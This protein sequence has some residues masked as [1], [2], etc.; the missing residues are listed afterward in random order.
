MAS[1]NP[2]PSAASF[3][4]PALDSPEE[5]EDELQLQQILLDSLEGSSEDTPAKRAELKAEIKSLEQQLAR[6]RGA[7]PNNSFKKTPADMPSHDNRPRSEWDG[8]LWP[9]APSTSRNDLWGDTQ[10]NSSTAS[11]SKKRSFGTHF[12]GD[13]F[14]A[15][16]GPSKSRRTSPGPFRSSFTFDDL[17]PIDLSGED[18][19]ESQRLGFQDLNDKR[20]REEQDAAYARRLDDELN[21]S[22]SASSPM[23]GLLSMASHSGRMH[24]QSPNGSMAADDSGNGDMTTYPSNGLNLPEFPALVL[25]SPRIATHL[26]SDS[27]PA[28][29][30]GRLHPPTVRD[31]R[32][33]RPDAEEAQAPQDNDSFASG[34]GA[35]P[36]S[37]MN[38]S[39]IINRTNNFDY[40]NG[41]D[42]NGIPFSDDVR[43]I[44]GD[45]SDLGD[46][47]R[48]ATSDQTQIKELLANIRPDTEIL[49]EGQ[50]G[51]PEAVACSLY[52]HQRV[53]LS[54]MKGMENDQGKRGGILADDM[55]LGKTISSLAL[56]VS[57]QAQSHTDPSQRPAKTTLIIGPV[58]LIRQW[59]R[60]IRTKLKPS[61]RLSVFM[62]HNKKT[63]YEELSTYDVVMTTYGLLASEFTKLENYTKKIG[64]VNGVVD[65]EHLSRVCP[66]IGPK[67]L[68]HRVILD[69]AQCIKNP[70]SKTARAAYQL[71]AQYRW[72][73]TGTPMMNSVSELA[74]LIQFLHIKP[75]CV[76]QIFRRDF[77]SLSSKGGTP[78]AE[79]MRK[80]QALLKAIMLR[81][82]KTSEIDGQ[83]IITL[84]EKTEE[85]VYVVFSEDEAL[86]YRDLESDSRVQFN[87][88]LRAG[89]V[90]KHYANALAILLR[91]RQAC[92]HPYLHI[93]DV[94][95]VNNEV[96]E[97]VM[98]ELAKT[99]DSEV[100]KRIKESEGFECPICMDVVENPSIML[101]CG[102][103][104]C[105]SCF[106][107]LVEGA[108]A[109]NLQAGQENEHM[110]CPEC[111]GDINTKKVITYEI[112]KRV[113]MPEAVEPTAPEDDEEMDSDLDSDTASEL[114]D[115]ADEV[116]DKG[117]LAGF[118]VDDNDLDDEDDREPVRTHS[119]AKKR[120]RLVVDD[121]S[122]LEDINDAISRSIDEKS[123][124]SKA[125]AKKSKAKKK[126]KKKEMELQPHM[127]NQ[128]RKNAS[129]NPRAHKRYMNYLKRIWLPSAK[130][131]KCRDL[132]AEIQ[133][134]EEKTIVFS[135]WTILLDLLEVSIKN[136]LKINYRRYDG[137]MT[138][139]QRDNAAR[140]FQEKDE[141]KVM[142]VSL[143]AGNAG[144]NLTAA[145][146]VI[147]MDPFW[148]PYIEMQAIDRA[149]RIGQQKPVK[150]HRILIKDTVEDRIINLQN[151]KRALVD[152]ALDEK[153][154]SNIGRLG[155]SELRYLFGISN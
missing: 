126:G 19:V 147:I 119:S 37:G 86:Y 20:R 51:T 99:L 33:P 90:G 22:L 93:G 14:D 131:D 11:N 139:A 95:L 74:S 35:G 24:S 10:S 110:N 116:D 151:E 107:R 114:D 69:E 40:A 12:G 29:A 55:G 46:L 102:H 81:R 26:K 105:S 68:F 125:R 65:Q 118:V 18:L 57:N 5:I 67:S 56:I 133:S 130:V 17:Q 52:K 144:L 146:Q 53:A 120:Q 80:L 2:P 72:C 137:S 82:S 96:P 45:L 77:G 149:Y 115:Y 129:R 143:K 100:V 64:A 36:R 108:K 150:V 50:D 60:E 13:A 103:D 83:P 16:T 141:A 58:A 124:K 154:A 128:L 106:L 92:C 127:L 148:N 73:L 1:S 109:Q 142:L 32:D 30:Y 3:S 155:A 28:S 134:T 123:K 89:T 61:H 75:Y 87:K 94:E 59:E 48:Y 4:Q 23:S 145:S 15:L 31:A 104:L 41:T 98:L 6:T 153:A 88:Y 7:Q 38:L 39:Q 62:F 25:G 84:E 140:D 122:D 47:G 132:I 44:I 9:P 49:E 91:L 71:K 43:R 54:W 27:S 152:A 76:P 70:K 66:L 78:S 79:A 113:Y 117:N 34:H 135:Q 63:S 112:F 21:N 42:G 97:D 136:E 121:S 8:F 101:P 111:R 138:A 85:I